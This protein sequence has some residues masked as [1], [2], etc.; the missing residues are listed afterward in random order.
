MDVA[1]TGLTPAIVFPAVLAILLIVS[2]L[3]GR[4][5]KFKANGVFQAITGILRLLTAKKK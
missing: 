1:T 2:E 3:L 4:T 5:S